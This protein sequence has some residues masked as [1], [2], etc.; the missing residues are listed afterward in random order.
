[1]VLPSSRS[2]SRT[3]L[4]RPFFSVGEDANGTRQF[5]FSRSSSEKGGTVEAGKPG[6]E[7]LPS[8]SEFQVQRL[9]LLTRGNEAKRQARRLS[10]VL[11]KGGRHLK[12]RGRGKRSR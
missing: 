12:R 11:M 4:E 7:R 5:G 6:P 2:S 1:M 10:P 8:D 9:A 3:E